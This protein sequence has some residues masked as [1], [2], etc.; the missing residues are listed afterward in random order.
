VSTANG[1]CAAG[2]LKGAFTRA[3]GVWFSLLLYPV[4]LQCWRELGDVYRATS[5]VEV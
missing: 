5:V 2:M 4:L 3:M 1:L